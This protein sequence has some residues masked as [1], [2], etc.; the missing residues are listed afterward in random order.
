METNPREV[1]ASR[2][3][4][5][6]IDANLPVPDG[7]RLVRIENQSQAWNDTLFQHGEIQSGTISTLRSIH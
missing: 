6:T 3:F 2:V 5:N 4:V 1:S 7:H